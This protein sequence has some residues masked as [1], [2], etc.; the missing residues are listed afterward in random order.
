MRN[1][2]HSGNC[3]HHSGIGQKHAPSVIA[4][5]LLRCVTLIL[6]LTL[7][8]TRGAHELDAQRS[9]N[10]GHRYTYGQTLTVTLEL[11][12]GEEAPEATL[13]L[14]VN[15]AAT[16]SHVVPMTDGTAIYE[17]DLQKEPLPPYAVISYWWSYDSA[18]G[19]AL[20]DKRIFRYID[21]RYDWQTI[22][23]G[24]ISVHWITGE[25][26][27]VSQAVVIAR[28][29]R[30]E[31]AEALQAEVQTLTHIYIYPS[32][33]DLVSALQLSGHN[34]VEGVTYPALGVILIAVPPNADGILLMQ[35]TIPH[36]LTH[37]ILYD[38]LGQQGY[39]ALPAWLNEGLATHFERQ[40]DPDLALAL[41]TAQR[42]GQL[43]P[44]DQLCFPFPEAP[45][46]ARLAYAESQSLLAYLEA[47]SGWSSI[48]AL[49]AAY[50]DGLACDSGVQHALHISLSQL[51]RDWQ[52]WLKSGGAMAT[53]PSWRTLAAT[54]NN[55]A[56][57]LV[58]TAIV[59]LPALMGAFALSH[60]H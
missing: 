56:P 23:E 32:E 14:Q 21:N 36:E 3:P 31:I 16:S 49:L 38:L 35:R 46:Q 15:N 42:E 19:Q 13:Y 7:L 48:R 39:L 26:N 28:D 9:D 5:T 18:R 20:T 11:P 4:A 60:R 58:L 33:S 59:L 55:S 37:Q 54:L 12:A 47:T 8:L 51:E 52:A 10:A 22:S 17:R 34:W 45:E 44:I 53:S 40:P 1:H 6:V 50:R 30:E 29:S 43:I 27:W 24:D 2:S 25:R 57:W 41:Q